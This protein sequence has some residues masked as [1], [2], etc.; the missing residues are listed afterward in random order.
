VVAPAADE[1]AE[2]R[3]EPLDARAAHDRDPLLV[4][5]GSSARGRRDRANA[6]VDLLAMS[7]V[8]H[9]SPDPGTGT[10]RDPGHRHAVA[11]ISATER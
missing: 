1:H 11:N 6:L 4:L 2:V 5:A 7:R 8:L 9:F 10:L 3:V